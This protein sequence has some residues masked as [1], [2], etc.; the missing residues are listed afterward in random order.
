M[1]KKRDSQAERD[2]IQWSKEPGKAQ[3][4][5]PAKGS[6]DIVDQV[7]ALNAKYQRH[8]QRNPIRRVAKKNKKQRRKK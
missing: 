4:Q 6:R 1:E 3:S 5:I 8:Q 2:H 7:D